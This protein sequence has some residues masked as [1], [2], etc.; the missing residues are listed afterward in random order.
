[1]GHLLSAAGI[2]KDAPLVVIGDGPDRE[3]LKDLARTAELKNVRFV[4]PK[5][6]VDLDNLL[7]NCRFVIVPS[8]WHENFPY[9]I[10]QA[11]AAGKPVLGSERGGIPELV[12]HGKHGWIYGSS[13]PRELAYCIQEAFGTSNSIIQEMGERAKRFVTNEFNDEVFYQRIE[14]IYRDVLR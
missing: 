14:R 4:G 3:M 6:G 7:K 2:A 8:L 11:F 10:L 5:W 9:V 12:L 13:N 1:M